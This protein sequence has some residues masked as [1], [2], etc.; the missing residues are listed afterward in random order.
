[1]ST[2]TYTY[3]VCLRQEHDSSWTA[4]VDDEGDELRYGYCTGN[5]YGEALEAIK[6]EIERHLKNK[7]RQRDEIQG[8]LGRHEKKRTL[9]AL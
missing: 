6:S 8:Y 2:S 1:M 5:T 9:C 7:I 3:K 4:R